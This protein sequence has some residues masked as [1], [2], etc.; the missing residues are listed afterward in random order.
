MRE[1]IGF[2][3]AGAFKCLEFSPEAGG[4]ADRAMVYLHGAGERGDNVQALKAFGL[5]MLL[6][7][8]AARVDCTVL[9]PL[10]EADRA[11]DSDRVAVFVAGVKETFSRVALIGYSL[12]G[13]G[14][15][16]LLAH[17]GFVVDVAVAIAARGGADVTAPQAG[18]LALTISGELDALANTTE[19]LKGVRAKGGISHELVL[20]GHCHFISEIALED[21]LCRALLEEHG[22]SISFARDEAFRGPGVL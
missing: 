14:V 9:C 10:L 11:W 3:S 16:N 8:A 22:F 1:L 20:P 21:P 2:V 18:V 19:F 6:G 7:T 17:H 15:C 13:E 5:P 4:D 12:G